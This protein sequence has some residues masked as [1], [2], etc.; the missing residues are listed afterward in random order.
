MADDNKDNTLKG[1]R[2]QMAM[3]GRTPVVLTPVEKG[4]NPLRVTPL[5][6]S[7]IHSGRIPTLVTPLSPGAPASNPS[8]APS[9]PAPTEEGKK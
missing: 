9:A 3:D 6:P 5:S 8:S 7:E 2:R 4:R 1:L